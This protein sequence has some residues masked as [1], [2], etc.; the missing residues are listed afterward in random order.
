[1]SLP[2]SI[3]TP[4]AFDVPQPALLFSTDPIANIEHRVPKKSL[5]RVIS[6]L[7]VVAIPSDITFGHPNLIHWRL[8]CIVGEGI[9][10]AAVKIDAVLPSPAAPHPLG[11]IVQFVVNYRLH[12]GLSDRVVK[13]IPIP[14]H[15]RAD[16]RPTMEQMLQL[17]THG[18]MGRYIYPS[19][20]SGCTVWTITFIRLLTTAGFIS[21]DLW[22]DCL[23]QMLSLNGQPD[24]TRPGDYQV[25][26][27]PGTFF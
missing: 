14:L 24:Q 6:R 1:M 5:N 13:S 4:L 16:R 21:P 9:E 15:S 7:F 8:E 22:K 23:T 27:A 17:M 10:A 2:P 19:S 12:G 3:Q 25:V 18:P 26:W 20:N 11:Q